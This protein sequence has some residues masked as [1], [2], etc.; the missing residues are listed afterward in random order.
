MGNIATRRKRMAPT[1]VPPIHTIPFLPRVLPKVMPPPMSPPRVPLVKAENA[2]WKSHWFCRKRPSVLHRKW[3]KCP[4]ES[5]PSLPH[6]TPSTSAPPQM[7]PLH[8]PS[9]LFSTVTNPASLSQPLLS[10]RA[11]CVSR[12]SRLTGLLLRVGIADMH[13]IGACYAL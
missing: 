12:A 11:T 1:N 9:S 8:A 5:L 10:P 2:P 3:G 13:R 4:W 6:A 7:V